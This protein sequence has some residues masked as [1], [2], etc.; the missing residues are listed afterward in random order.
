MQL[1]LDSETDLDKND[2]TKSKEG[3]YIFKILLNTVFNLK[4]ILYNHKKFSLQLPENSYQL[5]KKKMQ[6]AVDFRCI[7]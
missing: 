4:K 1:L 6:I 3:K 7:D 5:F 2:K